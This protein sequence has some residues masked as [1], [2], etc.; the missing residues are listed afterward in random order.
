MSFITVSRLGSVQPQKESWEEKE[1]TSKNM[2]NKMRNF[3]QM[4]ASMQQ[5]VYNYVL[6]K[7]RYGGR[8][9]I[10]DMMNKPVFTT[11]QK[12]KLFE[13]YLSTGGYDNDDENIFENAC[14]I[15]KERTKDIIKQYKDCH[16]SKRFVTL[17]DMTLD[18]EVKALRALSKSKYAPPYVFNAQYCP[19][20]GAIK[21]LPSIMR[22]K[23]LEALTSNIHVSYNVFKNIT[24]ED[25]FKRLLFSSVIR[26][27]DRAEAVWEKYKELKSTGIEGTVVI[28]M[29]CKNCQDFEVTLTSSVVRTKTKLE[30]TR[31]GQFVTQN[32]CL[33]C[34]QWGSIEG[35]T[36]SGDIEGLSG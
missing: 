15:D 29:R 11:E 3:D 7:D 14:A 9:Y 22:L 1:V 30:A 21:E 5:D 6:T 19:T 2:W 34:G 20:L 23:S 36:I 26:H 25:E 28:K 4:T 8:Y 16:M 31:F 13:K 18:E 33:L 10:N 35:P 12:L 17:N 27:R 32:H 24:D